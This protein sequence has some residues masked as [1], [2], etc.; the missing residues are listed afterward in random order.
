[1]ETTIQVRVVGPY[2]D[3]HWLDANNF[4]TGSTALC[5]DG[6]ACLLAE[7]T[8]EA[9]KHITLGGMREGQVF[10]RV[11]FE[12]VINQ[13][14]KGF[15]SVTI[16]P[17]LLP[18]ATDMAREVLRIQDPLFLCL[19][20]RVPHPG[21]LHHDQHLADLLCRRQLLRRCERQR[22]RPSAHCRCQANGSGSV[23]LNALRPYQSITS[24]A[25]N[26][27]DQLDLF[28]CDPAKQGHCFSA[29][30]QIV[31]ISPFTPSA[32]VLAYQLE[33]SSTGQTNPA[34]FAVDTPQVPSASSVQ[35]TIT[36][37]TTYYSGVLTWT[38]SSVVSVSFCASGVISYF[39][40]QAPGLARAV[41]LSPKHS[42]REQFDWPQRAAIP[43]IHR[44]DAHHGLQLP[45]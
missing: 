31:P 3:T 38:V 29:S 39:Y 2:S 18:Q 15:S 28:P 27:F 40:N 36:G 22:V 10:V 45:R 12:S 42:R 35:L 9:V 11:G 25:L 4:Y 5:T 14:A 24:G 32:A 17:D 13:Y 20:R 8:S 30:A 43:A 37:S 6:A 33:H 16:L 19:R 44:T 7:G 41:R 23:Q 34:C 26:V 1:M 21:K